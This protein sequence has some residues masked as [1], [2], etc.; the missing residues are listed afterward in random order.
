MTVEKIPINVPEPLYLRLQGISVFA[1]RSV[2][3]ILTSAVAVALPPSPDLPPSV[4]NELA[5]MIWLSDQALW[6]A[7]IPTFTAKEQ[8]RLAELND[9]EDTRALRVDEQQEQAQLLAAYERSVLRRAQAFAILSRRGHQ[10]PQLKD[11]T[12]P[13]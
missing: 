11:L 13:L 9:L 1:H 12:I 4:A 8:T 5:E 6:D 3:E 10:I 2:E 7:T